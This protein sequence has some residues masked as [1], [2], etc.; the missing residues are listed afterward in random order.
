MP[1]SGP[2][3]REPAARPGQREEE[4]EEEGRGPGGAGHHPAL[5]QNTVCIG[6][7]GL[8]NYLLRPD[9]GS[10]GYRCSI[11]YFWL[12]NKASFTF[13]VPSLNPWKQCI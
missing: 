11:P 1:G 9:K 4:E 5:S 8:S 3:R 2:V 13:F 6:T 7:N 12:T 10:D